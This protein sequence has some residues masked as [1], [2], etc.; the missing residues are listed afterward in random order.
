MNLIE[1]TPQIPIRG[2]GEDPVWGIGENPIRGK[3]ED[4]VWAKGVNDESGSAATEF[5]L[6]ALPLFVPAL[7]FFLSLSQA[8]R[9]EMEASM[10]AREA[11]QTF[12]TSSNDNEG[13]LR[14]KLLLSEYSK[15][16]APRI[17]RKAG[18]SIEGEAR[19][20]NHEIQYSI[21][22]SAN[23]C[24]QPGSAVE[25]TL[26]MSIDIEA[27]VEGIQ[28]APHNAWG[29]G[30]RQIRNQRTAVAS[31]RGYVDKWS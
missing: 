29:I 14:L 25:L 17:G 30:G 7:L 11:L 5:I 26:F 31:A 1:R 10:L 13:H 12:V 4:P 6:I 3:G 19:S 27:E 2:K 22:C 20:N 15:I 9:A 8:S 18:D 16:S 24:I 21:N 23:P 28:Q